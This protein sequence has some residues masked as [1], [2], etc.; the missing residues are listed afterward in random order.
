LSTIN[1]KYL[2]LNVYGTKWLKARWFNMLA[3]TKEQVVEQ[4][5]HITWERG[6]I[7]FDPIKIYLS[8]AH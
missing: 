6:S 4:K 8:V 2:Y 7:Y 1:E 3:K 5:V